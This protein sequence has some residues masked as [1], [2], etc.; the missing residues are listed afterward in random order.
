MCG[1]F[2]GPGGWFGGGIFMMLSMILF[3]VLIIWGGVV[4]ARRLSRSS[5]CDR[6]AMESGPAYEILKERYAKGEITRDEF[7]QIKKDIQ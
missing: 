7:E 6:L 1:W 5:H 3:W 4:L 2:G